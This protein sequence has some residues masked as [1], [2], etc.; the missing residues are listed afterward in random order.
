LKPTKEYREVGEALF[1]YLQQKEHAK[2]VMRSWLTCAKHQHGYSLS[3][4]EYTE[5]VKEGLGLKDAEL[6][7]QQFSREKRKIMVRKISYGRRDMIEDLARRLSSAGKEDIDAFSRSLSFGRKK[8]VA[9]VAKRLSCGKENR[10]EE[11]DLH[12][13]R[14]SM[15]FLGI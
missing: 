12:L 7:P 3:K 13:A 6:S 9:E 14:V 1:D 4:L 11:V 15:F 10:G 2:S 5:L 8:E